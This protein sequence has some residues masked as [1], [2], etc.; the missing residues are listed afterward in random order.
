MELKIYQVLQR[1]AR[2]EQA[3]DDYKEETEQ[4][5]SALETLCESLSADNATVREECEQMRAEQEQTLKT[6]L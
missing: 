1:L 3:F 4:R 6:I 2:I 5:L